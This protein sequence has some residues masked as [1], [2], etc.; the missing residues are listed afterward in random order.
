MLFRRSRASLSQAPTCKV[1]C[2]DG[3]LYE[4][5]WINPQTA[6]ERGIKDGDIVRAHNER[7]SVLCGARVWERIMPGVVYVDH[8]SRVD[9]IIPGK[10]DRGGAI[11][12]ISPY[13]VTSKHCPGMAS[14]GYLVEVE[15]IPMAQMEEWKRLYPHEFQKEY[16]SA[17]GLRF[18]AWVERDL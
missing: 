8:G 10:L 5:L 11:N 14:S 12:L 4:P 7:G 6:A 9:W 2:E 17:S 13:A 18:N 3:Y 1:K 15:R 16:E